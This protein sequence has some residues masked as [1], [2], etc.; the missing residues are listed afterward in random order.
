MFKTRGTSDEFKTMGQADLDAF[1]SQLAAF[2]V[3]GE[4][5]GDAAMSFADGWSAAWRAIVAVK[6]C[7]DHVF[8]TVCAN[9][10]SV[11]D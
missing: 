9:C 7:E 4:R 8:V 10:G 1:K 6:D 11:Q 3:K 5:L 2:G